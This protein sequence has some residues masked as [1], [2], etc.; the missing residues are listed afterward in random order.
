MKDIEQIAKVCH[1]VNAAYCES[2]GDD[3]QFSWD[4]APDWQKESA[5]KG[6]EFHLDNPDASPSASHDSWLKAKTEAGWKYGEKK[7]PEK[8][9]HPCCVPYDELP[10]EQKSKDYIFKS[11]VGCFRGN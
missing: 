7:D 3:S 2:I 9:E 10:Q 11:I 5:I 6:V 4:S 1:T 8:K